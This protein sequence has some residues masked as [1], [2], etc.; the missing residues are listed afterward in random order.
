MNFVEFGGF[1]DEEVV[2]GGCV[3]VGVE[4]LKMWQNGKQRDR[5]LEN[6]MSSCH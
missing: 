3:C 4:F 5:R 2:V 6:M 1:G